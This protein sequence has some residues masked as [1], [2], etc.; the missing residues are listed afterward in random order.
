VFAVL[1]PEYSQAYAEDR[2]EGEARVSLPAEDADELVV[3]EREATRL[4]ADP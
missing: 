2:A 1:V 3:G 4:T